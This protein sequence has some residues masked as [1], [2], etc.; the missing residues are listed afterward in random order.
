MTQFLFW[1]INRKPLVS[2][3]LELSRQCSADFVLLAE[4][5]IPDQELLSALNPIAAKKPRLLNG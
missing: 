1:N 2:L 4:S 5:E 3:I